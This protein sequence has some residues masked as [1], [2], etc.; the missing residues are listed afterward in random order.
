M[1]PSQNAAEEVFERLPKSGSVTARGSGLAESQERGSS[2][3]PE[4]R[5]HIP[6]PQA[7]EEVCSGNS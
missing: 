2:R 7:Q 4:E 5:A 6:R 3:P 1:V